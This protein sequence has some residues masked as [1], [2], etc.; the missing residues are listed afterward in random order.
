V[1]P[2]GGG[3]GGGSFSG[4]YKILSRTSGRGLA[5]QSASTANSASVIIYD[6]DDNATDNDEWQM[7]D[8][9]S[10]YYKI[11]NRNSGKLAQAMG[12]ANGSAVQQQTDAGGTDQHFQFVSIP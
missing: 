6:Y 12:T 10:G 11:K 1:A 2:S 9:G 4:Y 5:V 7:V 8:A 3:G